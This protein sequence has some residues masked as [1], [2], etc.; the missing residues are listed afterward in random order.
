MHYS[1]PAHYTSP[2]K[3]W[4]RLFQLVWEEDQRVVG[5]VSKGYG[6]PMEEVLK[7]LAEEFQSGS[8]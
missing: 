7:E 2:G 1:P 3:E 5:L 4:E 8:H 6:I